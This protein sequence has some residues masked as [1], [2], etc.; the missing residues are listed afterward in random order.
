MG[1]TRYCSRKTD[2]VLSSDDQAIEKVDRALESN[3]RSL[4]TGT[5]SSESLADSSYS[6]GLG[7]GKLFICDITTDS[8]KLRLG[9]KIFHV[10]L[11]LKKRTIGDNLEFS[12][13]VV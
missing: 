12:G 3:W 6:R 8:C 2:K 5:I 9:R 1:L 13:N 11:A 10:H 4:S 7:Y